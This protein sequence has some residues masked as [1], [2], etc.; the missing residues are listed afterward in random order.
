VQI[1]DSG[2]CNVRFRLVSCE[3][4]TVYLDRM[5]ESAESERRRRRRQSNETQ[6]AVMRENHAGGAGLS[7]SALSKIAVWLRTGSATTVSGSIASLP[8]VLGGLPA[9]QT[10][11]AARPS[12]GTSSNG[13]PIIR[14]GPSTSLVQPLQAATSNAQ[15]F[16]FAGWMR[17]PLSATARQILA[18]RN[19]SGSANE[20]K[21]QVSVSSSENVN[22]TVYHPDITGA[23]QARNAS[24]TGSPI[25]DNVWQF[26]YLGINLTLGT[27]IVSCVMGLGAVLQSLTFSDSF[28]TPG[29]MP[30][31]FN[32]V[33]GN[34]ILGANNAAA[35]SLPFTGDWGPNFW[36]LNN[37]LTVGELTNMMNFEKPV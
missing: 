34:L 15:K 17:T 37:Q 16:G 2:R 5:G 27:E 23:A 4:A 19:G 29:G 11:P 14:W 26:L 18:I 36:F 24:I 13:Y 28:G 30:T 21:I 33:T 31:S 9:E 20:D 12:V 7:A 35:S 6:R 25:L 8:D 22:T 10:T 1:H 32:T 3:G